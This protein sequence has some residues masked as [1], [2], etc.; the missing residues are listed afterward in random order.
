MSST[1]SKP[2][3]EKMAAAVITTLQCVLTRLFSIYY[4]LTLTIQNNNCVEKTAKPL[5]HGC[6]YQPSMLQNIKN[7]EEK[8][9]KAIG[10][11]KKS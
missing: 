9:R 4:K 6:Y 2:I 8:R 7:Y 5:K 11:K 1:I 3:A 10:A